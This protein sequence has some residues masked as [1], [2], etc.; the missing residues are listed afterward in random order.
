MRPLL[1]Q[2][3]RDI[4]T[5]NASLFCSPDKPYFK[6]LVDIFEKT[7]FDDYVQRIVDGENE[8]RVR[9]YLLDYCATTAEI[10]FPF[11][12]DGENVNRIRINPEY[13][14]SMQ[15]SKDGNRWYYLGGNDSVR[16]F[17]ALD[18]AGLLSFDE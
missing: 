4:A 18:E 10:P 15:V 6:S 2:S 17:N 7:L 8:R 3:L 9:P 5:E 13:Q 11:T 14:F 16:L 12:V 1:Q